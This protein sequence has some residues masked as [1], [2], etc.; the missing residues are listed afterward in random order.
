MMARSY[1][2]LQAGDKLY[3]QHNGVPFPAIIKA[4]VVLTHPIRG[5]CVRYAY[6]DQS[7]QLYDRWFNDDYHDDQSH[8]VLK[9]S[10]NPL[11]VL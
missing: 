10:H 8:W 1:K 4:E 5:I 2:H 9:E 7:D 11:E 3:Y 6:S